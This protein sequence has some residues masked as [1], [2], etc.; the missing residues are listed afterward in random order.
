MARVASVRQ[1]PGQL[2]GL[3]RHQLACRAGTWR[4]LVE[5]EYLSSEALGDELRDDRGDE[6]AADDQLQQGA[7][8]QRSS[9]LFTD[10][11]S[12]MMAAAGSWTCSPA[13]EM[14]G[15]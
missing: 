1:K 12:P 14:Y 7:R 3:E 8:A 13:M 9:S 4:R 15:S 11:F 10:S 6:A 5:D 2:A